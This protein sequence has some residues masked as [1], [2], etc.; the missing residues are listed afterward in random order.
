MNIYPSNTMTYFTT[1]LAEPINLVGKWQV[2][3][4]EISFPSKIWNMPKGGGFHSRMRKQGGGVDVIDYSI[5]PGHYES[6]EE[7]FRQMSAFSSNLTLRPNPGLPFQTFQSVLIKHTGQAYAEFPKD[8]MF[9][10]STPADILGF[11]RNKW[12]VEH[13]TH[14]GKFE[15]DLSRGVHNILLYTDIVEY[16][17][18]GDTKAP[19]LRIVPLNA[20]MRNNALQCINSITTKT[21]DDKE[22]KNLIQHDFHSITVHLRDSTGAP[23][24]FSSVGRVQLTLRFKKVLT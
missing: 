14:V 13:S 2:A 19:I 15:V 24:G 9:S 10:E 12:Y 18:I 7:I 5:A 4:T 16:S 3:L 23:I 22:Y 6:V 21:F 20:R 17:Y 1:L 8:I 11:E